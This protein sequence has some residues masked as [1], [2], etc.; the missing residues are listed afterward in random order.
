MASSVMAITEISVNLR[1]FIARDDSVIGAA[2]IQV[3]C[4]SIQGP[5]PLMSKRPG[6]PAAQ[7]CAGG[8]RARQRVRAAGIRRARCG[9]GPGSPGL[10]AAARLTRIPASAACLCGRIPADARAGSTRDGAGAGCIP[11]AG[12]RMRALAHAVCCAS[13][14][15]GARL[16]LGCGAADTPGGAGCGAALNRVAARAVDGPRRRARS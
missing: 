2:S 3:N 10:V 4:G 13:A 8:L 5:P 1:R 12:P 9:C 6:G 16:C 15:D 14:G 11:D 7:A